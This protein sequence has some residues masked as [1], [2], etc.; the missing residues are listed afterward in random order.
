MRAR[1]PDVLVS[2]EDLLRALAAVCEAPRPAAAELFRQVVFAYL[3]G[4]GDA[5]AKNFSVLQGPSG[6][7]A[8]AP[9]YDLPSTQPYGDTTVALSVDGRRDGVTG[10][11]FLPLADRVGVRE[12]AARAIV[13][14]VAQSADAWGD[15]LQEL[16]L[17]RGRV[18]KLK[19]FVANR[20]KLL[21]TGA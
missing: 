10:A 15:Q 9:A 20:Q 7:W 12:R 14:A 2:T 13:R 16:P 19:R 4:N 6:R 8:P 1:R 21:H 11:K 5:H 3:S 18:S 17:D